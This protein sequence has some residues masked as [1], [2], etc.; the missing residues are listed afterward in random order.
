MDELLSEHLSYNHDAILEE[1]IFV[2]ETT[3]KSPIKK[4]KKKLSP[5]KILSNE[6]QVGFS[7]LY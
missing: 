5:S 1:L 4:L 7:L 2:P 3:H 6:L